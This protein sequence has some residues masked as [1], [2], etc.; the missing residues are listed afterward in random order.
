VDS[1]AAAAGKPLE[2]TADWQYEVE[3]RLLRAPLV[4]RTLG[5]LSGCPVGPG[6][7]EEAGAVY[8]EDMSC[9]APVVWLSGHVGCPDIAWFIRTVLGCADNGQRPV[10]H[11]NALVSRVDSAVMN[12]YPDRMHYKNWMHYI[13]FLQL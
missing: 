3:R 6:W 11:D 9:P 1:A 10:C 13:L 4:I 12:D 7:P 2:M 8:G 5:L